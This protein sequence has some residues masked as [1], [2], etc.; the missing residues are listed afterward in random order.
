MSANA[1]FSRREFLKLVGIGTA[2]AA[3]CA[4]RKA[5]KL[6]PYLVPPADV[7]PGV[8]NWYASTCQECSA[9]CG[10]LVK[11]R[12]GR[13]IKI[14][15]NPAHPLN[16]G[17]LCARG[18]A[19]L[20]GLYD[21]D[22]VRTPMI[23]QGGA[24]RPA[25]WDEA[26]SLVAQKLGAAKGHVA[27]V[28]RHHTGTFATLAGE[29]AAGAGGTHLMY[30]PFAY[31]PVRAAA[32]QS[33]GRDGVP[34]LDFAKANM[35]VS[36][37]AD[38]L[39]SYGAP[40][41]QARDFAAMRA[42]PEA[43]T[44]VAVEPRMSATGSNADEWVPV[45][46]GGEIAVALA[47]A[48]VIAKEGGGAAG[49][50]LSAWT[51][52][53]AS[54]QAGVP[55]DT[56]VR[57]ARA[58]AKAKPS[59]AVAGGVSAQ[60][61]QATALV[62]AV[63]LLNRVAGNVGQT[64]RPDLALDFGGVASFA[65]LQKLIQGMAQGQVQALVV[66]GANPAY[67]V[68]DWAGFAAAMDKVPF[69]V[70]LTGVMDETAE[71][72][73][74]I[75]PTQHWLESWGDA[76][77]IPGVT[78]LSQPTM[79]PLPMMD[80]RP[81]GD[82]L[83][84][85]AKSAGFGGIAQATWLD[86]LKAHWQ[87][88]TGAGQAAWDRV[89]QQGGVFPAQL[90]AG[91]AASAGGGSAT[92]AAPTF[93]GDGDK[94]LVLFPSVLHDGRGANKAWLQELP[95]PVTSA[96]WGSW[97][98]LNPATAKSLGV[99]TGELVQVTTPAGKLTAPAYVTPAI[100]E[101]TIAI[102][103]GQG[104]TSYGR[105]AKGRGVRALALLP[106]AVD[107]A[108]G[109]LAYLATRARVAKAAGTPGIALAQPE[110]FQG[111]RA[112]AQVIPVSALLAAG[113]AGSWS[114]PHPE[115]YELSPELEKAMTRPGETSE[116]HR[117][118][119]GE[120]IPSQAV[121]A[122]QPDEPFRSERQIPV[123]A[124][125]YSNPNQRHRWAM[126]IDVN[127]CNGCGACVV[128]CYA[129]NNIPAVGPDMIM[130]GR[131]MSWIR[132]ERYEEKITG[133]KND[134]RFLPMMCQQ[135]T[136]APCEPV[137]PVYATYHNPE[138]LNA[139]VYNRCVGTRYCSNNCPYKVRAFNWFDY[140]APEKG[141]FAFPEPLNWQLNP[142]VTV[143]SKGVM[144]K[145]TFCVQRILEGKGKARDENRSL[146]D[147]DIL[148]ACQQSCPSQ[149]IVFG[150]LMDPN[151]RVAQLSNAGPRRYWALNDLNTKPGIT[152]LRKIDRAPENA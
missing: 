85:L 86:Y 75:L 114:P 147:G 122:S 78:T 103:L 57:L 93:A 49:A 90:P 50:D 116:P 48:N 35:V 65:D 1:P 68:P 62:A 133:G 36:F 56:I 44:F 128:A 115:R 121:H 54:A 23:R 2:G 26:M 25:R 109:A 127:T 99:E 102:P 20:Q 94:F 74:V 79:Q 98:E 152:Y 31:E 30:E 137:C 105:Y 70:A 55:A 45:K 89:V 120:T 5:D 58:F 97:V 9:G 28:T 108:S 21:P 66:E 131:D 11:A 96:T 132:I 33:F 47:M 12:E 100:R 18:Q 135:C 15:G 101:D 136:D 8:A 4:P 125:S 71:R 46:P 80:A 17:G 63:N 43:G 22:R 129:E 64:V 104:H 91:G 73:D 148:T 29:W 72:C 124:G 27:L 39:G 149:A 123:A 112:V 82:I 150:D 6:I 113:A 76:A 42:R 106:Q 19:A 141:T 10:I 145:C 151:S 117:M 61:D 142:D 83:I 40:T 77:P 130:R 88:R 87:G 118:K 34:W 13:T 139:Q 51:P 119:P 3:G 110:K 107:Q 138:G 92:F 81:A 95:D 140:A 37:G 59:L 84:A 144:E 69:K 38:F 143:R 41:A 52:E 7:L 16:R 14:E 146:K 111:T 53:A 32:K 67:G 134:V 60:S 24:W 126:A